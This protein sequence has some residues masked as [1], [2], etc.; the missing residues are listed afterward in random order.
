MEQMPGPQSVTVRQ[1]PRWTIPAGVGVLVMA[2]GLAASV[3]AQPNVSGKITAVVLFGLLIALIVWLWR[4]ANHWRDRLEIT[5]D[6]ITFR[7]G[8]S[9]P[10]I[11]LARE[12]G[13]DLRLIPSLRDHGV[14]TGPRLCLVGSGD[15]ITIYGFSADAIRRGCTAVGWRFAD[16]TAE[17]ADRDVRDLG[18]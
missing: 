16:G 13:T 12:Q 15:E 4:R 3:A 5:P 2:L 11:V 7:H 9:G 14:T 17:E 10:S 8:R 1:R 6:A 18:G